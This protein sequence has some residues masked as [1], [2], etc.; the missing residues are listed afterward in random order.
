MLLLP[1]PKRTILRFPNCDLSYIHHRLPRLS[2]HSRPNE[3]SFFGLHPDDGSHT[4]VGSRNQLSGAGFSNAASSRPP[5]LVH[6]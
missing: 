5:Q 3:L 2:E 6:T 4:V 1:L